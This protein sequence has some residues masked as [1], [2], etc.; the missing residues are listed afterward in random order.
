MKQSNFKRSITDFAA[1]EDRLQHDDFLQAVY[2]EYVQR[3]TAMLTFRDEEATIYYH[4]NQLCNL[5]SSPKKELSFA[6]TVYNRYLPLLRSQVLSTE[7]KA[8]NCSEQ[9]WLEEAKIAGYSY[10]SVLPEILDHIMKDR[11]PESAQVSQ[12]YRFS[13][14]NCSENHEIILLDVEAAFSCSGEKTDR[15]DAVFYHTVKRRLMFVEVKRLSDSRV[16]EK[17]SAPAEV[18]EQLNRYRNTIESEKDNIISQYNRVINYY[19]HL[20]GKQIP[21]I[22][23]IEPLLGLLL[24][25][26]TRSQK[27]QTKKKAVISTLEREHFNVYAIGNTAHMTE[28][29]TLAAIYS[30]FEKIIQK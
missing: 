10:R 9:T 30:K 18:V 11:S 8:E 24:V 20:S 5:K 28:E 4:G 12:F 1:F 23:D 13:P 14:L 21:D 16:Q 7:R 27:D 26:F 2:K 22:A 19:N 25:E 6:P 15:I 29:S 17:G 3:G